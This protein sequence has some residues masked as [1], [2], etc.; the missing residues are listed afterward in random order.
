MVPKPGSDEEAKLIFEKWD[1][2]FAI[3]GK[4][5]SEDKFLIFFN[6]EIKAE[7]PLKALS[8]NAPEYNRPWTATSKNRVKITVVTLATS[9]C[10]RIVKKNFIGYIYICC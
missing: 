8:G 6:D 7:L 2:D 5:I 9:H 4:T 10:N 1:L 3:I